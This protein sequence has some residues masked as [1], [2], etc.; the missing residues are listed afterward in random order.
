MTASYLLYRIYECLNQ[1]DAE[2]FHYYRLKLKESY[3]KE[4]ALRFRDNRR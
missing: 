4:Y 1:D 3:P 2:G